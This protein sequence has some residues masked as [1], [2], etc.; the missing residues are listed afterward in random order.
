MKKKILFSIVA[1]VPAL[2]FAQTP[3]DALR[4]SMLGFGGTARYLSTAGAFGAIGADFSV[5]S[6]NPAGIGLFR[7]TEI[8]FSPGLLYTNAQSS[9]NGT[10]SEDDRYNLNMNSAGVVFAFGNDKNPSS[11][12]KRVQLGFGMNKLAN[13]SS[14]FIIKGDNPFN[15]II[16]E[17]QKKA[18]GILP[19]NLDPYDTQLAW[20][21]YLLK[22]TVRDNNGILQYTSAIPDGGVQQMKYVEQRGSQNEMVL[23]LGGN[24]ND[25]M[26][27][28]GTIG[29]PTLNFR[30]NS[31]YKE[32]DRGD[33]IADF[34]SMTI[35]DY[36]FTSGT[37]INFKFGIIGRPLEWIRI[38]AAVHTPTFFTLRD[39]YGRTMRH[40]NDFGE[41]IS[42]KSPKGVYN[43]HLRTPF[44]AMA[45][46]GFIIK[47]YGFIGIDYEFTDYSEAKF[48]NRD[49]Y[50]NDVNMVIHDDYSSANNIRIGGEL[51]LQALKLR[52]GYA[53]YG[54]PYKNSIND[55]EKTSITFGL[56]FRDKN[57]FLDLAWIMT[58]YA[59]DYYLYNPQFVNAATI[60]NVTNAVV[61]TLG[62]RM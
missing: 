19:K 61:M 18:V 33:S 12:W 13:Y 16:S 11:N 53:L 47:Q 20:D 29:F 32:I 27:I 5:L 48:E 54:S 45:S 15:S 31:T 59:E 2:L 7:T 50:F 24:Y 46:L 44:R 38:G 23:T 39:E 36:V 21:L 1:I 60:D 56:G 22:D 30:E 34:R 17:F 41:E 43:Y 8:S 42:Q 55:L 3:S 26:Y 62:F 58:T 28:G 52:A 40:T 25:K 10:S 51:N 4:Y 6:T 9:Y 14:N 57:Y 37:G 49:E 35:E